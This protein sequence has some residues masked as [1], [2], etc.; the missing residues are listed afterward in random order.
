MGTRLNG[1]L[2][3][4]LSLTREQS[5][6]ESLMISTLA[7]EMAHALLAIAPIL[8]LT[9]IVA[10]LAPMLLGGWNQSVEALAPVFNRLNPLNGFGRMF[11]TNSAVNLVKAFIKFIFL[12][13]V[14]IF[15]LKQKSGE[16]MGLGTEPTRVAIAHAI[17]LTGY[18]FLML[19]GTYRLIAAIDIPW[20]L[21]QHNKQLRM[22]REE[23]GRGGGGGGGAPGG[24]GRGRQRRRE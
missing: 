1:L 15:I 8:G 20:Q 16:L 18:A 21:F 4:S 14:S 10:L 5:V 11:S 24:G 6:D 12:A 22:T 9:L 13:L 19:A 17:S 23:V 3:A 2:M 7:T